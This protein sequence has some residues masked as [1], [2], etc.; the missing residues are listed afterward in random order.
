MWWRREETD[1]VLRSMPTMVASPTVATM[2]MEAITTTVSAAIVASR[3]RAATTV[4]SPAETKVLA[5][6]TSVLLALM[7]VDIRRLGNRGSIRLRRRWR[8][9]GICRRGDEVHRG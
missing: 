9:R 6:V 4:T 8:R 5:G 1:D 3:H 2:P 7:M